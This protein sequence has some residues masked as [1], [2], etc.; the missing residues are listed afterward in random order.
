MGE[1]VGEGLEGKGGGRGRGMERGGE[2]ERGLT[3]FVVRF[4]HIP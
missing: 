3:S 1:R 4:V 2:S